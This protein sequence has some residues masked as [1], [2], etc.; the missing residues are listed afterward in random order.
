MPTARDVSDIATANVR[1]ANADADALEA[2][3]LAARARAAGAAK[4]AVEQSALADRETRLHEQVVKN[5]LK[6]LREKL[7]AA[8]AAPRPTSRPTPVVRGLARLYLRQ[9]C[10][11][12]E[13][14]RL[15]RGDELFAKFF[16]LLTTSQQMMSV[17]GIRDPGLADD[18]DA[19]EVKSWRAVIERA[20]VLAG[21]A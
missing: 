19:V 8:I 6:A 14:E 4:T 16:G 3:V 21:E 12:E 7:D 2:E 20:R 17:I 13:V 11:Y 18:L 15:A 10:S 9:G 5:E 1:R